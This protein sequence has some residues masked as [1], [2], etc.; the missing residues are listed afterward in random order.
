MVILIDTPPAVDA[1]HALVHRDRDVDAFEEL[2]LKV[3]RP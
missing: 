1:G 2:G 3:I